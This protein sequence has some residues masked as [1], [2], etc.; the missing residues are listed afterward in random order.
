MPVFGSI[1]NSQK[2]LRIRNRPIQVKHGFRSPLDDD[3]G[4]QMRA[5]WSKVNMPAGTKIDHGETLPGWMTWVVTPTAGS[6]VQAMIL[7][8]ANIDFSIF[9]RLRVVA[10][11]YNYFYVG[12]IVTDNNAG[13]DG[14]QYLNSIQYYDSY[15]WSHAVGSSYG[16]VSNTEY[17]PHG[18]GLDIYLRMRRLGNT[19]YNA[20]SIDGRVWSDEFSW[21]ITGFSPTNVGLF[22]MAT[23]GQNAF[24][25]KPKLSVEFFRYSPDPNA[26]L[27]IPDPVVVR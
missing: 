7:P 13:D 26:V 5:G 1:V 22:A 20:Y 8:T 10:R 14:T 4:T 24:G 25:L 3:L 19:L 2:G 12:L 21:D 9:T 23:D 18:H 27:S 6:T 11:N 15:L 16:S 17:R